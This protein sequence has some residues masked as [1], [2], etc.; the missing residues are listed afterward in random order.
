MTRPRVLQDV[1]VSLGPLWEHRFRARSR[2]VTQGSRN[3]KLSGMG[4][5][6]G[7]FWGQVS[8][9]EDVTV[10]QCPSKRSRCSDG[11]Q[12]PR[13]LG[14]PMVMSRAQGRQNNPKPSS[15]QG[16]SLTFELKC[17]L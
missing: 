13:M 2:D 5:P 14:E 12:Q 8:L 4:G 9:G 1:E 16:Q 6:V 10:P 3:P 7:L 17:T 11:N 15:N